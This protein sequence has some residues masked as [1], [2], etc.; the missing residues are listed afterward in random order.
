MARATIAK[1]VRITRELADDIL[2][3]INERNVLYLV[4]VCLKYRGYDQIV[5]L[6]LY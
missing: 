5:T 2:A 3:L 1:S 6:E 4:H